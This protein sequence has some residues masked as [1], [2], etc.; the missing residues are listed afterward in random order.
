MLVTDGAGARVMMRQSTW[1]GLL[2]EIRSLWVPEHR[3]RLPITT[4][5]PP[6]RAFLDERSSA[7][8]FTAAAVA[9]SPASRGVYLLYSSGRLIYIGAAASGSG[10]RQELEKHRGGA[11]GDCTR[12]ASAFLYELVDD[13]LARQREYLQAH[14]AQYGGREPACNQ[15]RLAD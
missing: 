12:G 4:E 14:R 9:I 8:P 2:D 7:W 13:P 5:V 10:I 3:R 15:E 6:L 1:Q 11:Y